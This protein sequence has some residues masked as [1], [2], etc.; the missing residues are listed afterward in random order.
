MDHST[1]VRACPSCGNLDSAFQRTMAGH[2]LN[3]CLQC[4]AVFCTAVLGPAETRATYARLYAAGGEFQRHRDEVGRVRR[5]LES[6]TLLTVG[7]A[8]KEFFRR[9]PAVPGRDRLLDIGCGTGLF[10]VAAAQRG[11]DVQ[12]VDVSEEAV[13][14]GGSVHGLD[15][16]ARPVEEIDTE[17]LRFS[18]VTA[19]EVL[20]HLAEP[21]RFL[22]SMPRLLRPGG[23]FAGSVP[24]YS[25]KRYRYGEDLGLS[26]V[27][28]VHVSFWDPGSIRELLLRA[29][30][31][32]VVVWSPRFAPDLLRPFRSPSFKRFAR[33]AKVLVGLDKTTSMFFLAR[34]RQ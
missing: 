3:K 20:E 4:G 16:R 19:W 34:L 31:D 12:G 33:F 18:A 21:R 32:E 1:E 28:P 2:A 30:L 6:G 23:V 25:R 27:P 24:D 11:W 14:L 29:G 26:S 15:V 13:A 9:V 17:G 10:L 8:R 5:A 7:W 22:A